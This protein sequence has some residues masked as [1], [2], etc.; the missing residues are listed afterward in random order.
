M[1]LKPLLKENYLK[2]KTFTV[3]YEISMLVMKV[4]DMPKKF[5]MN[6]K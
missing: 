4:M 6:L 2:E 5:G 1:A 3:C